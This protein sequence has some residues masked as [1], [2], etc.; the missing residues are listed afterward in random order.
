MEDEE[1]EYTL[2]NK[3]EVLVYQVPPASSSSGH[4]ADDWK[5]CIWRGRCQVAGK[6]KELMIKMVDP[7]SEQLRTVLD[8]QRRV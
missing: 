8:T 5:Q 7:S 2:L 3:R 6:G 4:K 1:I